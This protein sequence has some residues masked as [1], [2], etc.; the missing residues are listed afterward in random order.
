MVGT[1]R[2]ETPPAEGEGKYQERQGRLCFIMT[3]KM[4]DVVD[5]S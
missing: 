1:L 2:E 5:Q 4:E 3:A